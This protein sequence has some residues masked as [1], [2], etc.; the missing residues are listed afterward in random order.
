MRGDQRD[1]EIGMQDFVQVAPV[2]HRPRAVQAQGLADEFSI[3]E[4]VIEA[5]ET[6]FDGAVKHVGDVLEST[7]REIARRGSTPYASQKGGRS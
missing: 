5:G 3:E 4:W 1:A 6:Y 7:A 2:L